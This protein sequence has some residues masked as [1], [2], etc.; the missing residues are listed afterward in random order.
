MPADIHITGQPEPTHRSEPMGR[1]RLIQV[2]KRLFTV[3]SSPPAGF[4]WPTRTLGALGVL[5]SIVAII[6]LVVNYYRGV[7][8][9]LTMQVYIARAIIVLALGIWIMWRNPWR[10]VD[11]VGMRLARMMFLVN[12]LS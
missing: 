10:Q 8:P 5:V 3:R 1:P 2:I 9:L 11:Q 12:A 4:D 6:E 7:H